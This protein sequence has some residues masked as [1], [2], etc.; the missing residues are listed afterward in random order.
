[1]PKKQTSWFLQNLFVTE[2]L[3]VLFGS[4]VE[5][6]VFPHKRVLR[7]TLRQR[8]FPPRLSSC[9]LASDPARARLHQSRKL[10]QMLVPEEV[11]LVR[12]G[13]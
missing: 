12:C 4:R 10:L 8:A 9:R 3:I 13:D 7:V 5:A 2:V 6:Q 11:I 1:M